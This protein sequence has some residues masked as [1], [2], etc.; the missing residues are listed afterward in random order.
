MTE[1]VRGEIDRH[2]QNMQRAGDVALSDLEQWPADQPEMDAWSMFVRRTEG[3]EV[4]PW[5]H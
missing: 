3:G 4:A 5:H 2:R 1:R